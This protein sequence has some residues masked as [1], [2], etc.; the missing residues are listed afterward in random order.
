VRSFSIATAALC[1][2]VVLSACGA[3]PLTSGSTTAPPRA[4]A[5][6]PITAVCQVVNGSA[7]RRCTPGVANPLVTK[8]NISTTVC[9]TG[10]TATVRPTQNYTNTLKLRQMKEY[11]EPGPTS[12]YE[13]DHFL[14]LEIGGDPKDPRNLYPQPY[15]GPRGARVKDVE[16]GALNKAICNSR[17]TLQ[18]AQ[19]KMRAD[20]SY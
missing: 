7:D 19:D 14:S 13:E 1:A 11:G 18:Q 2:A 12:L 5:I 17:M 6:A 3:A 4:G 8:D 16:E 10:W 15:A 20:W 9:K